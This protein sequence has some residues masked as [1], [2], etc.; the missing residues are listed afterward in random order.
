M[1]DIKFIKNKYENDCDPREP[2]YARLEDGRVVDIAA[3]TTKEQGKS[4]YDDN[5]YFTYVGKGKYLTGWGDNVYHFFVRTEDYPPYDFS[6]AFP[7]YDPEN[8]VI[9]LQE[10]NNV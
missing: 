4:Y 1:K 2:I 10:K 3:A 8:V 6:H 9:K 7:E 5:D